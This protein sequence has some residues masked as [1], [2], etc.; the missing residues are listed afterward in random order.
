MFIGGNRSTGMRTSVTVTTITTIRQHTMI[1]NVLRIENPDISSR[2]RHSNSSALLPLAV[3]FLPRGIGCGC[4][5]PRGRLLSVRPPPPPAIC[6]EFQD[7]LSFVQLCSAASPAAPLRRCRFPPQLPAEHL[8]HQAFPPA[9]VAFPC[10]F[11][12]SACRCDCQNR[13]R[14]PWCASAYPRSEE[15]R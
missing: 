11:Q 3:P 1:K 13:F 10:T 14:S 5:S 2:L 9:P 6:L 12:K 4:R 7:A 15:R 8:M